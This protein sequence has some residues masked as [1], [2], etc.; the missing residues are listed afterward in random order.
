MKQA[1][2]WR[3]QDGQNSS[4]D[5]SPAPT[6][7]QC[8][9]HELTQARESALG[10]QFGRVKGHYVSDRIGELN[11]DL[12]YCCDRYEHSIF[13]RNQPATGE[14]IDGVIEAPSQDH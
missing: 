13:D 9:R 3:T 14:N 1:R 8:T 5:N 7:A 12:K 6:P 10:F 11:Q 4:T 2:Q